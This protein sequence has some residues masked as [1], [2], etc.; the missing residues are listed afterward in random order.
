MDL[1]APLCDDRRV[2]GGSEFQLLVFDWDGTLMDSVG[3]I[4]GCTQAAI[5]ELGLGE[6]AEATI[7]GTV[8]LGLRETI[9]TLVPGCD[10]DLYA[11]VLDCYRRHWTATYRDLPL[12]FAE[13]GGMLEELAR[14][15]Y[16]LAVATGKSRRGLDF[17]L[18][19]SGLGRLF[20]A[21]RTADEALSKPHPQMLLDI[22]DELGVRAAAAVMVGDSIYDLQMAQNAGTAAVG[23]LSGAHGREELAAQ[24]PRALLSRVADLPRWLASTRRPAPR[25]RRAAPAAAAASPPAPRRGRARRT[26]RLP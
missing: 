3:P 11:R 4:V 6:P 9:D 2:S 20:H 14:A 26:G 19:R 13:V 5:R 22:L 12:L 25:R 21:T 8:G 10:E 7:R 17:A 16:L 23:V 1:P 18:D 24:A 15:G